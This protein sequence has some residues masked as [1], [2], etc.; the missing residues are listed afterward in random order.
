MGT[1][2]KPQELTLWW[3]NLLSQGRSFTLT[4][5]MVFK[6]RWL[7]AA[8][9]PRL[10]CFFTLPCRVSPADISGRAWHVGWLSPIPS[11]TGRRPR[12]WPHGRPDPGLLGRK[13]WWNREWDW[14]W[15]WQW[16]L[17]HAADRWLQCRVS[18]LNEGVI[19]FWSCWCFKHIRLLDLRGNYL[20]LFLQCTHLI[21]W[22]H[23]KNK[24]MT[25]DKLQSLV[26]NKYKQRD[27]YIQFWKV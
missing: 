18:N 25:E 1:K 12:W 14:Y 20:I 21:A 8:W 16:N 17:Q 13:K 10:E 22:S 4:S 7:L 5:F 9:A 27:I 26:L 6:P 19:V 3:A 23:S 2:D 11:Q 15:V 24:M